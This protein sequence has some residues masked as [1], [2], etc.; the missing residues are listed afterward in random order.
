MI[1]HRGVEIW[2]DLPSTVVAVSS[3]NVFKWMLDCVDIAKFCI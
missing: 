3:F 2:N 1:L